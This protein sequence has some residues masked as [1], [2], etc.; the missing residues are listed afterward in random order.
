MATLAEVTAK[1]A[2]Q[3]ITLKVVRQYHATVNRGRIYRQD[4]ARRTQLKRGSTITLWVS[5][6]KK[7]K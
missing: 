3:G 5:K 2:T 1:L 4:P 7:P 6:G